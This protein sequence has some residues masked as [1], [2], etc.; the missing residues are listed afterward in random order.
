MDVK[1]KIEEGRFNYRAS[2]VILNNEKILA[3]KNERSPYYY[4]PGGRVELNETAENAIQREIKEELG[5]KAEI[6]RPLWLNQSFLKRMSAVRN[7]MK[8]VC[9][10]F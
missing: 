6:I 5:I 10:F 4:L 8:F 9:T 1:F 3:M 2:G 7:I